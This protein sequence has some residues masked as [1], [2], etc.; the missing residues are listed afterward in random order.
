[1]AKAAPWNLTL[2]NLGAANF[3]RSP[4]GPLPN[5]PLSNGS[6]SPQW[7]PAG[8]AYTAT[9][10]TQQRPSPPPAFHCLS[11]IFHCIFTAFQPPFHHLSPSA[12]A[13]VSARPCKATGPAGH[14]GPVILVTAPSR[15]VSY[16]HEPPQAAAPPAAIAAARRPCPPALLVPALLVPAGRGGAAAVG[17]EAG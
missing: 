14:C 7:Q 13:A 17:R 6:L 16:A 2:I 8:L 9:R 15:A 11:A 12:R 1:M 4:N 10:H 5:G 3:V